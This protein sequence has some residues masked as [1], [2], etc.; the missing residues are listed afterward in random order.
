MTTRDEEQQDDSDNRNTSGEPAEEDQD[1][2]T[3]QKEDNSGTGSGIKAKL[4]TL[5]IA[6]LLGTTGYSASILWT[7]PFR[8]VA[9][10]PGLALTTSSQLMMNYIAL[11]LGAVTIGLL[12]FRVSDKSIDYID[13]HIPHK[14]QLAIIIG[15]TLALLLAFFAIGAGTSF[16]GGAEASEHSMQ[17][18][19]SNGN[20]DPQFILVMIPISF[21]VIGPS[22]E[23]IFRNLVQKRLYEDFSKTASVILA[24]GIFAL[25]HFPTY[26]T[27]AF[28]EILISLGSVFIFSVILGTAYAWSKNLLI[29]A[30]MHGTYNAVIFANWYT[31]LAHGFTFL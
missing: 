6:F 31:A 3:H 12:Y 24:S 18:T 20:V 29:P 19:V 22:E 30:V 14:R 7:I 28:S 8:E 26:A 10:V 17:Q 13:I 15:G 11:V 23:F 25:I 1:T 27:G 16:F 9:R 21:L 2:G 5:G 4:K